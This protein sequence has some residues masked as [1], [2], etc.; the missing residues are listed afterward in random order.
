MS[1]TLSYQC[2][3]FRMPY[4]LDDT[5]HRTLTIYATTWRLSK[6]LSTS[7]SSWMHC[8]SS[9]CYSSSM[10]YSLHAAILPTIMYAS[11]SYDATNVSSTMS[12]TCMSYRMSNNH[13]CCSSNVSTTMYATILSNW[14]YASSPYDDGPTPSNVSSTMSTSCMSNWV[15]N[16]YGCCPNDVSSTLSTTFL[17]NR[18]SR[19]TQELLFSCKIDATNA[20]TSTTNVSSTMSSSVMSYG[21]PNDN[22]CYANNVSTALYAA[23]LPNRLHASSSYDDG[24]T[25]PS[26]VS[27]AMSTSCM[28]YWLSN[29]Y[30]CCSCHVPSTLS[31]TF[32]SIRLHASC[33]YDDGT[34]SSNVPSTMSTSYLPYWVSNDNGCCSDDVS[35]TLSTTCLPNWLSR[36]TKELLFSCKIDATNA[37]TS[38]TNV[39]STLSSSVMSYG[40]SND[41]GCYANNVSTALYATFL[42]NRLYASSSSPYDDGT[43]PSNVST[44]MPTSCMSN[45]MSNDNGCCSD[46]VSSTLS[47]TCLPN[48]LSR[49]TKKLLFSE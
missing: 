39:S 7:L 26:N 44:A 49:N 10:S 32:L 35:S 43:T 48:W 46:D 34:T 40:M 19:N 14:L 11:S 21:M 13:G 17:P 15:S 41:H 24:L 9:K 33:S 22:G 1:K 6:P 36:N 37:T 28:P 38:T 18:L 29:D 23:F 45:R 2:M 31:T 27:T 3:P 5:G 42:P 8:Y 20:T 12:S 25:T 30:G 47:T 16:D 4:Y